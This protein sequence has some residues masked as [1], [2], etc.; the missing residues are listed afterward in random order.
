MH[1]PHFLVL[2]GWP[3]RIIEYPPMSNT[4]PSFETQESR[5]VFDIQI[6]PNLCTKLQACN[7]KTYK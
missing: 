7:W 4:L 6:M 3:A 2:L 5:W 1:A